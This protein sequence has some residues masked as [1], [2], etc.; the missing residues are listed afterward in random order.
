MSEFKFKGTPGPWVAHKSESWCGEPEFLIV[1][2]DGT[3]REPRYI[4]VAQTFRG[5][6]ICTQKAN[7][8]LIAAALDL[9]NALR[10]LEKVAGAKG[11]PTDAARAALAKATG[12]E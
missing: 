5:D 2:E 8:K 9:L 10:E 6:S 7:A 1:K 12:Q 3:L 11:I 4:G